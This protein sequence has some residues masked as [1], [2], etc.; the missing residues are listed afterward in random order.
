MARW[1]DTLFAK[2]LLLSLGVALL[3]AILFGTLA[4]RQLSRSQ[5]RVTAPLWAAAL[6]TALEDRVALPAVLPAQ[7]TLS[8]LPGPPPPDA[9]ELRLYPRFRAIAEELRRLGV[10]VREF[11]VSGRTGDAVNWL[12][13]EQ[14]G[15]GLRWIGVRGDYEGLDVRARG[16]FGFVLA[17]GLIGAGAWSLSRRITRPVRELQQAMQRFGRE[18]RWPAAGAA[19]TAGAAGATGAVGAA[20]APGTPVA[21]RM[22][23]DDTSTPAE[24]RELVRQ[25]EQVAAERAA[26]DAERR[27][28]LAAISHDLRS[29]LSRI[30]MAAELLPPEGE[31]VAARRDTIVRNVQAVDRLLG[32]F[33]DFARSDSEPFEEAVDLVELVRRV[34]DEDSEFELALP[35]GAPAGAATEPCVVPRASALALERALRNLLDNARRHGEAPVQVSLRRTGA[36]EATLAVRD[37]GP[38]V[39]RATD[40]ARLVQPF[41][42]GEQGRRTPGTGLGLAIV[43]RVAERCGGS[44]AIEDAAPGLRAV[45]R[46]PIDPAG[47]AHPG[48][49]PF[50]ASSAAR[51][52]PIH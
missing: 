18:G 19:G 30:R 13:I 15:G 11:R 12:G 23:G 47:L 33:I 49:A 37:H 43:A 9:A 27:T 5:A 20:A 29:P 26:L 14:P 7:A 41:Q 32:S 52:T 21:A 22:G 16:F 1:R 3:V 40:R 28:M 38:G 44:F 6:K 25:F 46:L 2:V 35:D 24:L 51:S 39:P 4:L 17:L 45:L 42:R 34:A 36:A 10:P 31:G 8:L 48:A 50:P